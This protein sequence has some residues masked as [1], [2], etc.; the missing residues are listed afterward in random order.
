MNHEPRKP[1]SSELIS[2][3]VPGLKNSEAAEEERVWDLGAIGLDCGI[4]VC[5][6]IAEM[7]KKKSEV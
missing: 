2:T 4:R 6:T 1:S 7:E 3:K 5:F